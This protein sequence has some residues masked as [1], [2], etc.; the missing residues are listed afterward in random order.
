M[1]TRRR[2]I[3]LA[4][5]AFAPALLGR[6]VLAQNAWPSRPVHFIVPLAAGGPTDTNARILADQLS[7]MWGQQIVVENKP[8]AG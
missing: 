2:L 4:T 6:A 7:K 1:L 8:G 3:G 5:S